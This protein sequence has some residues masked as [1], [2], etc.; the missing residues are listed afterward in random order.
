MKKPR[1]SP[2]NVEPQSIDDD[3]MRLEESELC[4]RWKW[5]L[6]L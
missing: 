3:E 5:N 1:I 6:A 4:D 2:E